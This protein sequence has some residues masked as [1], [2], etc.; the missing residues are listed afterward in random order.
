VVDIAKGP[1]EAFGPLKAVLASI[2][3]ISEKYQVCILT[4]IQRLSPYNYT[5]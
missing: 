3:I 5:L 2:S 4:L 1:A